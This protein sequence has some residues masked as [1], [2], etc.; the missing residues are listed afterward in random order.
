MQ[1]KVNGGKGN[2]DRYVPISPRLL[3]ELRTYWKIGRPSNY[4]F[5]GKTPDTP[6]SGA[7]VQKACKLAA[8]LARI[9]KNVT[10]HTLRKVY[11]YYRSSLRWHY[12]KGISACL[13]SRLGSWRPLRTA[14]TSDWTEVRVSDARAMIQ[15]ADSTT[16]VAGNVP[17]QIRRRI[18]V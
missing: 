5:P 6:L 4:L 10:P 7:T 8:A 2:K 12:W 1:L 18:T 17:S 3:E 14:A 16:C 13:G 11:S 15:G 9:T